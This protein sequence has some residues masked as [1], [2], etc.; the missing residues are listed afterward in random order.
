MAPRAAQPFASDYC[1]V[2]AC[3]SSN[4][5]SAQSR[6]AHEGNR[7]YTYP[8]RLEGS[9]KVL[10][11]TA[12]WRVEHDEPI[13]PRLCYGEKVLLAKLREFDFLHMCK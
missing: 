1:N 5:H 2:D 8:Q 10:T 6:A 12:P 7:F 13:L 11:M 3:I 9:L 4:L